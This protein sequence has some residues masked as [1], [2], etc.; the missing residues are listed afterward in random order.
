[1]HFR[2]TDAILNNVHFSKGFDCS[3]TCLATGI[4]LQDVFI[5]IKNFLH[6]SK[7]LV[8][9]EVEAPGGG[10]GG[11]TWPK[12]VRGCTHEKKFFHPAPEFLP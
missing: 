7:I 5:L 10:G 8:I 1:M 2:I 11:G 12:S 4:H 6:S 9:L 3:K